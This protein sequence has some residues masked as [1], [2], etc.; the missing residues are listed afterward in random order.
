MA[1]TETELLRLAVKIY[2]AATE[3][4]LW[5]EV[6]K[7]YA[8]A[9]SA[10]IALLRAHDFAA[11]HSKISAAFGLSTLFKQSY[12]DYYSN[13]NV[14]RDYSRRAYKPGAVVLADEHCPKDLYLRSEF[15]NDY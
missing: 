7:A 3:P 6:L 1:V 5:P 13:M 4:E 11:R 2:E 10:H 15:Y 8:D 12:N 9:I 14:W